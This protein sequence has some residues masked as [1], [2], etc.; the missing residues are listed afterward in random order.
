[1]IPSV[2]QPGAQG[3]AFHG[4]T[5]NG[6]YHLSSEA[7]VVGEHRQGVSRVSRVRVEGRAGAEQK[8]Q[9]PGRAAGVP[10][11]KRAS[12]IVREELTYLWEP[13]LPRG[14]LGLLEG[15]PGIGKTFLIC[16]LMADLSRGRPLPGVDP[17]SPVNSMILTQDDSAARIL[18]RL[19]KLDADLNRI[20]VSDEQFTLDSRGLGQLFNTIV[21]E[22][23]ALVALDPLLDFT[24]AKDTNHAK[25]VSTAMLQL[26]DLCLKTNT[27][28]LGVRHLRKA[29]E[30]ENKKYR[31]LGSIAFIAKARTTLQVKDLGSDKAQVEQI[32]TN[33]GPKGPPL[34]Y[35]IAGGDFAWTGEAPRILTVSKKPR[36]WQ[37]AQDWLRLKLRAGPVPT[38]K[39]EEMAAADGLS[40]STSKRASKGVAF[41]S[42]TRTG[43]WCWTLEPLTA[44]LA[45]ERRS[46]RLGWRQA[47]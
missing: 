14:F 20:I 7:T 19:E 17:I 33:Y 2:E 23:I 12:E 22:Q 18:E 1:M 8:A 6:R 40:W 45:P 47:K 21:E 11:A 34:V 24:A 25:E 42:K 41:S 30:E 28:V 10:G 29:E 46:L 32:K 15:D 44:E 13:Y 36:A 5:T 43:G 26:R 38:T 9:D 31:G 27:T 16:K 4:K 3:A 35:C 39:L 37:I